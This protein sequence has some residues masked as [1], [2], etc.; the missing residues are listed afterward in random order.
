MVALFSGVVGNAT[1]WF[2]M[3]LKKRSMGKA[4]QNTSPP[5]IRIAQW[6]EKYVWLGAAMS[7]TGIALL[8]RGGITIFGST[9]STDFS[10]LYFGGVLL[11]SG[12]FISLNSRPPEQEERDR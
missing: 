5:A 6:P 1:L 2:A 7:L 10:S 9:G 4:N 8:G 12:I 3:S 11:V